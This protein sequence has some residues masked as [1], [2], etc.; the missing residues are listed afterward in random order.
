LVRYGL[1]RENNTVQAPPAEKEKTEDKG[2]I[3]V[4]A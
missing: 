3:G 2:G 4:L 1:V